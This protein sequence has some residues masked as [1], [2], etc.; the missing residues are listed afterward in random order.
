MLSEELSVSVSTLWGLT[1]HASN[2][3]STRL[4]CLN[5]QDIVRVKAHKEKNQTHNIQQTT[6]AK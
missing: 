2:T 6:F 5:T 1:T 3:E 4:P